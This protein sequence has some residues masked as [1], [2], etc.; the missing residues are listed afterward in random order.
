MSSKVKDNRAVSVL[1]HTCNAG[2]G[3]YCPLSGLPLGP[4]LRRRLVIALVIG[5]RWRVISDEKSASA[6]PSLWTALMAECGDDLSES[7]RRALDAERRR[8]ARGP[9]RYA[10]Y[11]EIEVPVEEVTVEEVRVEDYAPAK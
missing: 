8:K 5:D 1:T 3:A 7:A 4:E 10:L 11:E 9:E 6:V 2:D